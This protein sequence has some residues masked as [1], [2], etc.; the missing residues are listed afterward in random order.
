VI[1]VSLD[2]ADEELLRKIRRKVEL[3]IIL[4]NMTRIRLRAFLDGRQPPVFT[5]S[6]GLYDKSITRLAAFA[7]L[8]VVMGVRGITFWD[9]VKYP[10]VP[11]AETVR[12]LSD[13]D[14]NELRHGLA[15]FD[16]A[17]AILKKARINTTVA[18]GF[19]DGQR[20]RLGQA[21]IVA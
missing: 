6:C 18:G 7:G 10:D 17:M 19:I 3:S 14:E 11:G 4:V 12:P 5:F 1:Q 16:Q 21:A 2:M 9:L 13:L 15:C 8:A 20:A